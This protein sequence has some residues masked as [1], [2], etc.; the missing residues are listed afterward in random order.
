MYG[1][2]NIKF[3]LVKNK[4]HNPN[5]TEDA[6]NYLNE[7]GK[8]RKKILSKKDLTAEEKFI[9]KSSFDWEK[10]TIQDELVWEEIYKHLI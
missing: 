5:Y 1:K 8:A 10:M 6:V 4:G 3:L 7:F 2:E 9:F